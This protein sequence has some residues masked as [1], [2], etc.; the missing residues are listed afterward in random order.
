MVEGVVVVVVVV[1][2]RG[3]GGVVVTMGLSL[4]GDNK[5]ITAWRDKR[6]RVVGDLAM[7]T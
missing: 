1:V 4:V 7:V 3:D 5:V 6:V 2:R